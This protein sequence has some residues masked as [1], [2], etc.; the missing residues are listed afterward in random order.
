MF[1]LHIQQLVDPHM[2]SIGSQQRVHILF[3]FLASEKS[4]DF[5]PLSIT[6]VSFTL[7]LLMNF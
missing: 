3:L 5:P 4:Y 2:A 7:P 6:I 1:Y